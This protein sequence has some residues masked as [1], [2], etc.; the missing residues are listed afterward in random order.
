MKKE[1]EAL[2]ANRELITAMSHDLRTPLT[3]QIGY[4]E[5][6][7]LKKYEDEGQRDIYIDKA[8]NNAFVM[9]D[10]TDKLFRYFLA[11]GHKEQTEKLV[12][13]DGRALLNSALREQTDYLKS[14]QFAVSFAQI[15]E[16]IRMQIDPDEF[17]RIFDNIFQNIKKYGDNAVPVMITYDYQPGRLLMMIQNSIR[18]D[19]SKVE[20]TKI[21]L[22]IVDKIMTAMGGSAEVFND[23]KI[24]IMQLLFPVTEEE[25][26]GI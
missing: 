2:T 18:E 13:V 26:K 25:K 9:K 3:R 5:I 22:K 23:G 17:A 14:Q 8:R 15:D 7:H 20:S 4:L 11:F 16:A 24:F 6:L 12:E 1:Y 19:L 10:T 21:G